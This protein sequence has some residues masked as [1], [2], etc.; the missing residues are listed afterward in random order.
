[1]LK[2]QHNKQRHIGEWAQNVPFLGHAMCKEEKREV[3]H[4]SFA[5][6]PFFKKSKVH[7]F[8]SQYHI[9]VLYSIYYK[10]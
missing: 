5:I 3:G 4:Y 1:M 6:D 2:G 8:L 10:A 9:H 7:R